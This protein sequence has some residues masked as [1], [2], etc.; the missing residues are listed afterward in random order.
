MSDYRRW[1]NVCDNQLGFGSDHKDWCHKISSKIKELEEE[2]KKLKN[3]LA[4]YAS[5]ETYFAIGIWPDPPCGDFV[6]DFGEVSDIDGDWYKPGALARH[7]LFPEEFEDFLWGDHD[8]FFLEKKEFA[9]HGRW[10]LTYSVVALDSETDKFYQALYREPATEMQ[11]H[12]PEWDYPD[13]NDWV[14]VVPVVI[15]ETKFEP[16]IG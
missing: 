3:A 4:F 5:P 1:C 12:D 14:E 8:R 16:V 2:N 13:E 15:S 9:D 10:N 6:D 7:V 11:E